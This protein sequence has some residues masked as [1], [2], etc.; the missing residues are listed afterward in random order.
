MVH[1]AARA[2][3]VR[4][5]QYWVTECGDDLASNEAAMEL[6]RAFA[7]HVGRTEK[8]PLALPPPLAVIP[9]TTDASAPSAY[10]S[11]GELSAEDL[12]KQLSL[13]EH[14]QFVAVR[15]RELIKQAWTKKDSATRAPNVHAL[16]QWFNHVSRW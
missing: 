2:E 14:Q 6:L 13:L 8:T 3:Y 1:G 12:A 15:P 4:A 7:A 11:V 9:P 5:I 10:S 16:T